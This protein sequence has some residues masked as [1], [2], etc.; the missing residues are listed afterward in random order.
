MA[1]QGSNGR[2][3]SDVAYERLEELLVTLRVPPG[4]VI[5]ETDLMQLTSI[6]R[7]PLR[8]AIQRFSAQGLDERSPAPG[9]Q[10]QRHQPCAS[11]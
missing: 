8:E 7:T 1:E 11:A 5:T 2:R 10:G 9:D 6:G 3:L 4:A